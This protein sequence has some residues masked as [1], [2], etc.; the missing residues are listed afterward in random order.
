[1]NYSFWENKIVNGGFALSL[2][3]YQSFYY[4][5]YSCFFLPH[6]TKGLGHTK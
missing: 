1:M 6:F 3:Y 5:F 4:C 2:N